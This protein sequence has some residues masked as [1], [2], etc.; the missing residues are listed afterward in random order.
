MDQKLLQ[1][2]S[3]GS[4]PRTNM[5]TRV[6]PKPSLIFVFFFPYF[7]NSNKRLLSTYVYIKKKNSQGPRH[8]IMFKEGLYSI[9]SAVQWRCVIVIIPQVSEK[10]STKYGDDHFDINLYTI[11]RRLKF[12]VIEVS[13][14]SKQ[15]KKLAGF[16]SPTPCS[17]LYLY[18]ILLVTAQRRIFERECECIT[19]RERKILKQNV[20]VS[21]KRKYRLL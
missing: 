8:K 5:V 6:P 7:I 17:D 19:N 1:F 9:F 16:T 4:H 14:R 21:Y 15:Q 20:C 3:Q 13:Y 10:R 12:T 11:C 2:N 18:K